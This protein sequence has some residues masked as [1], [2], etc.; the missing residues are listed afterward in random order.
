MG[1]ASYGPERF[2]YD[3]ASYTGVHRHGGP[4]ILDALDLN[5]RCRVDHSSSS[6]PRSGCTQQRMSSSL[7]ALD[8]GLRAGAAFL[9]A[10]ELGSSGRM[11]SVRR[12]RRLPLPR[13]R[14]EDLPYDWSPDW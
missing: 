3:K 9:S 2:F 4:S 11:G 1:S 5:F 6:T 12:A 13:L 7:D 14:V 10:R 8:L